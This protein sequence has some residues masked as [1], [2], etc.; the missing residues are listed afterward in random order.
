VVDSSSFKSPQAHHNPATMR[1]QSERF[2]PH[3]AT[4]G[5]FVLSPEL[6]AKI[7]ES[8]PLPVTAELLAAAKPGHAAPAPIAKA[9]VVKGK[10]GAVK[11]K[12]AV[13][14][15]AH[16]AG[17]GHVA[18]ADSKMVEGM[19]FIGGDAEAPKVGTLR[20]AFAMTPI[21][22]V[23]V[24][25]AQSH[26]GLA[27]Y[28]TKAG[29][30]IEL[31]E[32]GNVTAAAMFASA[33]A[34]NTLITWLLRALGFVLMLAGL[35]MVFKPL[36]VVADVLPFLGDLLR[37]GLFIMALPVALSLTLVTIAIAWLV[38]RPVIGGA[39]LVTGIAALVAVKTWASR[40]KAGIPAAASPAPA[41]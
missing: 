37:V 21:M 17:A 5:A 15:A 36:A 2:A 1:Y 28:Q 10:K 33:Q 27:P 9:K 34:E 3:R 4:L 8:E 7:H 31:L 25:A 13:A 19:F 16:A 14:S 24:V 35:M 30:A 41:T 40:K 29:G 23:S 20:V 6:L 32:R 38:Y 39:L 12:P 22:D 18:P 11:G 26:G